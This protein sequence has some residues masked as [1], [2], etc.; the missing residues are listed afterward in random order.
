MILAIDIENN[1]ITVGCMEEDTIYFIERLSSD[2]KK[3]GIEY[4]MELKSV[5]NLYQLDFN[6]VNGIVISSVVPPLCDILQ[7]AIKKLTKVKPIIVG[8]GVKTGLNI[9]MDNPAQVGSDLVANGVSANH[10]YK[11]PLIIIDMR[12]ATTISI[13]DEKK[14]YI[15]GMILPGVKESLETLA[16]QTSQL[17]RIGLSAP[18]RF[19][20]KNTIE[21]MKSGIIYGTASMLDGMIQ[22][23][24]LE[25]K[26]EP[27]IIAT[28]ELA[29]LIIPYCNT[30]IILDELLG[31]KGLQQIYM[32]NINEWK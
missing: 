27:T 14:N 4:A 15:G 23:I 1:T 5:F 6:H 9:C 28:G 18:K 19:I 26:E 20:G 21:S 8:P 10:F 32:K 7:E 31:M 16:K 25:L 17:P 29:H 13:I 11:A 22:R 30:Q 24:K 3:T 12:T 2:L